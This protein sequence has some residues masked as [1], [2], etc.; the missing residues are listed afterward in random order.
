MF[1]SN[2][3]KTLNE[4]E[5]QFKGCFLFSFFFKTELQKTWKKKTHRKHLA[6]RHPAPLKPPTNSSCS[7]L[8]CQDFPSMPG[9]P[10][11]HLLLYR[12]WSSL[13]CIIRESKPCSPWAWN[14]ILLPKAWKESSIPTSRAGALWLANTTR[15]LDT[16][17]RHVCVFVASI[18]QIQ[19]EGFSARDSLFVVAVVV[20]VVVVSREASLWSSLKIPCATY[21]K[22][23]LGCFFLCVCFFIPSSEAHSVV[24]GKLPLIISLLPIFNIQS[25]WLPALCVPRQ[26]VNVFCE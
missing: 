11:T 10:L 21:S 12:Y 7:L 25:W 20:I 18:Q 13:I 16:T 26:I 22:V 8:P 1:E 5:T 15:V 4:T 3:I 2:Q 9:V 24:C 19:V 6:P 23:Q 17:V 14:C